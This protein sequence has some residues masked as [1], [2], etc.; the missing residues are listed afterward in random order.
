M[1]RLKETL[2]SSNPDTSQFSNCF[3]LLFICVQGF[4]SFGSA[5]KFSVISIRTLTISYYR[6]NNVLIVENSEN[7]NSTTQAT[8][9]NIFVYMLYEIF[10]FFHLTNLL[11]VVHNTS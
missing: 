4:T 5:V 9:V 1:S 7:H 2:E 10:I 11:F 3:I 6:N 8:T